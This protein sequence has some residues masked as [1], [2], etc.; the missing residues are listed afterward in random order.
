M[1][2]AVARAPH[3]TRVRGSRAL[4]LGLGLVGAVLLLV[5]VVGLSI[6]VG[7]K[8][9]PLGDG[10]VGVAVPGRLVRVDGRRVAHPAHAARAAR[11]EPRWPSRAS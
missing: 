9:V 1:S 3:A 4:A 2:T 7:A 6:A 8:A 10:V 5:L 11:R